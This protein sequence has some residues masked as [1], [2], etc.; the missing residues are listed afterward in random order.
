MD[1]TTLADHRG[2]V[3]GIAR[4]ELALARELIRHAS[5]EVRFVA[6]SDPHRRFVEIDRIAVVHGQVGSFREALA[7]DG[8]PRDLPTGAPLL[9][10]GSAWIQSAN[11]PRAIT[12]LAAAHQLRLPVDAALLE[13]R[14]GSSLASAAIR[15]AT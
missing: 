6:F 12:A 14:S 10:V 8:L 2:R 11:Y 9:V 15:C 3:T 1:L 5:C 13:E 7:R 4:T